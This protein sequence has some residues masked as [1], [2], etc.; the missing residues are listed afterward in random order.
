MTAWTLV[1][2][3]TFGVLGS[4]EFHRGSDAAPWG[5]AGLVAGGHLLG[6]R[7]RRASAAAAQVAARAE[8]KNLLDLDRDGGRR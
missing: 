6:A 8:G 4:I 5:I 7:R 3:G 2:M 1:A